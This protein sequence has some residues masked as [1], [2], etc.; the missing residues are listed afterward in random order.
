M[1]KEGLQKKS[2]NMEER[3]HIEIEEMLFG[4]YRVQVWD[5]NL[6]SMLDR[7]YFCRGYESALATAYAIRTLESFSKFD[8]YFRSSKD[9]ELIDIYDKDTALESE[10]DNKNHSVGGKKED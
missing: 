6:C 4:D 10:D 8:I 1:E 7:E 5:E 3:Q 9:F 2:N